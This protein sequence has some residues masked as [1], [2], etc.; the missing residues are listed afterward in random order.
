MR[1]DSNHLQ[2][3]AHQHVVK[4][5]FLLSRRQKKP[6]ASPE[7]V[8]TIRL[9]GCDRAEKQRLQKEAAAMRSFFEGHRDEGRNNVRKAVFRQTVRVESMVQIAEQ[10]LIAFLSPGDF[11]AVVVWNQNIAELD[12]R[13]RNVEERRVHRPQKKHKNRSI[14]LRRTE[15]ILTSFP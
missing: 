11:F 3:A 10:L 7:R 13:N 5:R 6:P 12:E 9:D 14:E 4:Q 1:V 15:Q 2:I 8:E